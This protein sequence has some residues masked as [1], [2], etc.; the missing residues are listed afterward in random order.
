MSRRTIKLALIALLFTTITITIATFAADSDSQFQTAKTLLNDAL[1]SND[2]AK[3]D[4]AAAIF[5]A[6]LNFAG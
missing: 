5:Q 2:R 6:S 1:E 3:F 4:K